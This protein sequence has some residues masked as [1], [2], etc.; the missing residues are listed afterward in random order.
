MHEP[1][2]RPF[3]VDPRSLHSCAPAPARARPRRARPRARPRAARLRLRDQPRR[4][5]GRRGGPLRSGAAAEG[6]R[7]WSPC[8]PTPTSAGTASRCRRRRPRACAL[9][10]AACSRRRCSKTPRRSTSR[11]RRAPWPGSRPGSRRSTGQW[12]RNELAALQRARVFVDRVVPMAWPDDPPVGHFS[13]R[14]RAP[15]RAPPSTVSLTWAHIDGVANVRLQG[16]ARARARARRRHRRR[17]AGARR[18]RRPPPPSN[19]SARRST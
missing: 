8:S 11:S 3:H 2:V 18:R 9:R 6:A 5:R 17:R 7:P 12:L 4:P 19:G 1:R 13:M 14:R 15:S 10:S 16:G